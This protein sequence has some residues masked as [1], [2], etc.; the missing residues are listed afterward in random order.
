[1]LLKGADGQNFVAPSHKRVE[2]VK[3]GSVELRSSKLSQPVRCAFGQ[4][5]A[6][7]NDWNQ[8]ETSGTH[9]FLH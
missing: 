6:L 4:H 1:M 7:V 9:L 5:L 2:P 3:N 8:H